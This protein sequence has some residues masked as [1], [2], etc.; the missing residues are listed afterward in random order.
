[1]GAKTAAARARPGKNTP[2]SVAKRLAKEKAAARAQKR[3]DNKNIK[4]D[5]STSKKIV[6][7]VAKTTKPAKDENFDENGKQKLWSIVVP[8]NMPEE[9]V[10]L[11]LVKLFPHFKRTELRKYIDAGMVF[12]NK[13]RIWIAKYQVKANELLEVNTHL[14]DGE[15]TRMEQ[16]NII[17][18]NQDFMVINK[19]AGISV[20]DVNHKFPL[21]NIVKKLD[22][23]YAEMEFYPVHRIDKDTSGIVLVAKNEQTQQELIEMWSKKLVSKMYQCIVLNVPRKLTGTIDTNIGQ[24]AGRN[25]Y[26]TDKRREEGGKTALTLYKVNAVLARGLASIVTCQPKT[27]RSHQLRVHLSSIDC[28]IMGDKIYSNK[29]KN[30]Q[31]FQIANRQML[32]ASQLK[33]TLFKTEYNF[34]APVPGDFNQMVKYIKGIK[35]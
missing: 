27:G 2:A 3:I 33:F 16:S 21:F 28:P 19:P 14:G 10:D 26:G 24:H 29:F 34:H 13:K 25:Q 30:N 23:Q 17:F 8:K 32:H 4:V 22:P 20:E 11:A 6:D 35:V 12:I 7:V 5:L 9:R 1:M 15:K 18:E 31:L